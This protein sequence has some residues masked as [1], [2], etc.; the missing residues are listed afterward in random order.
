MPEWFQEA[1]NNG[2][3]VSVWVLLLRLGLAFALGFVVAGI[4]RWTYDHGEA[5]SQSFFATLVL[6]TIVIAMSTQ[7]IGNNVARA[8]SLVGALSIVR[9][10]T[11]VQDTRDTAFVIFS[12]VVGMAVGAGHLSVALVGIVITGLASFLLQP[13]ATGFGKSD[14]GL[15]LVVRLGLG[16]KPEQTLTS[17]FARYLATYNLRT[18]STAKQGNA[19]EFTYEVQFLTGITGAEFVSDLSLADGVTNVELKRMM[20]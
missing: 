1:I 14:A 12:V 19:L 17:I 3:E 2:A 13:K 20:A 10:R 9:F 11:V 4:Y 7:V 8:F 15:L 6:M 18:T 16:R 5:P